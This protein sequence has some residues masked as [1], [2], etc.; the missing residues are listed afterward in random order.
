VAQLVCAL[1][2]RNP[3]SAAYCFVVNAVI[4]PETAAAGELFPGATLAGP[5]TVTPEPSLAAHDGCDPEEPELQPA[6]S[7]PTSPQTSSAARALA[8]VRSVV[9]QVPNVAEK[10]KDASCRP[11]IVPAVRPARC[12]E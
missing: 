3:H 6:A 12:R 7:S 4:R 10:V 5:L 11:R 1:G 8:R 2:C 9:I